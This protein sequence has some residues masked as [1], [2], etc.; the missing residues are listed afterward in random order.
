[1]KKQNRGIMKEP[2]KTPGEWI[3]V[4]GNSAVICDDI[5]SDSQTRVIYVYIEDG[6]LPVARTAVW[7][8]DRWKDDSSDYGDKVD[9][10]HRF[11]NF[12]IILK[13]GRRYSR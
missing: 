10:F 12:A 4:G 2:N 6:I 11:N 7:E 9:K 1:M 5:S 8:T 13:A 3:T